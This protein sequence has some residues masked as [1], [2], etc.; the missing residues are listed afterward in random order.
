MIYGA[1]S[2]TA[3]VSMDQISLKAKG[4]QHTCFET[5]N[6]SPVNFWPS[7][8]R[9]IEDSLFNHCRNGRIVYDF[10]FLAFIMSTLF[11][12]RWFNISPCKLTDVENP[13]FIDRTFPRETIGV[14]HPFVYP[15]G[16]PGYH[17][18][19]FTPLPNARKNPSE[20]PRCFLLLLRF[21]FLPL[22]SRMKKHYI[23]HNST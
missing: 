19:R 23:P 18:S 17:S 13:A 2:A 5:K 8:S 4:K 1:R 16:S 15:M 11:I 6:G 12:Q 9:W 22:L 3:P 14:P 20:R 7:N 10:R 21:S